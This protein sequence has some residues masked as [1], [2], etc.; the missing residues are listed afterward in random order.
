MNIKTQNNNQPIKQNP[1]LQQLEDLS[2][3][4]SKDSTSIIIGPEFC[5]MFSRIAHKAETIWDRLDLQDILNLFTISY[6]LLLL[7]RIKNKLSSKKYFFFISKS[8]IHI[9]KIFASSLLP[10][11]IPEKCPDILTKESLLNLINILNL[12]FL[13]IDTEDSGINALISEITCNTLYNVILYTHQSYPNAISK[14]TRKILQ[15]KCDKAL[16]IDYKYDCYQAQ[17]CISANY[18]Q[19]LSACHLLNA[20]YYTDNT[21]PI[22]PKKIFALLFLTSK[23]IKLYDFPIYSL[24]KLTLIM[25]TRPPISFGKG[26]NT[27]IKFRLIKIMRT[28]HGRK[29]FGLIQKILLKI[30][31][32]FPFTYT[33]LLSFLEYF[34]PKSSLHPIHPFKKNEP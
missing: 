4:N 13:Y 26:V 11:P 28:P 27:C 33:E 12:E 22:S 31:E 3:K 1:L 17:H 20:L 6:K 18:V 21:T 23:I 16:D 24:L 9:S 7:K 2:K 34:N 30:S 25:S 29:Y 14:E 10:N 5:A 8:L 32:N 15:T 19:K